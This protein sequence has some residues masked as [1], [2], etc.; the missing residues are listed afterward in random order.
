MANTSYPRC[1]I[2]MGIA[3]SAD[4]AG[5][6]PPAAPLMFLVHPTLSENDMW[7]MIKVVEKVMAN[8]TK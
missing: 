3:I 4:N 8:V 7:N 1:L 2:K 6:T 5:N